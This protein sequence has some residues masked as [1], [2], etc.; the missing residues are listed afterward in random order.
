M[1][2]SNPTLTNPAQH[3]FEWKGGAGK[4]QWYDK[5]NEKNVEV[6]LPFEF[7]VLD[8]LFTITGYNKRS[9]SGFWSNEVYGIKKDLMYVKTKS[10]PF[11]A[12]LYENLTQTMKS[13]GKLARS[14]YIAHKGEGGKYMIGNIKASGSALSSWIEFRKKHA[15]DAG[16]VVMKRGEVQEAP[17]GEFYPPVFEWVKATDAEDEE[18]KALDREL[19]VYLK[20]Y[21][22]APKDGEEE[23]EVDIDEI[24]KATPEQVQDFEDRKASKQSRST[25]AADD[26]DPGP[27]KP[28]VVIE[29]IGDEPINLDD[30]PF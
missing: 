16:K 14:I 9:E 11:E 4:L 7:M 1:S 25:K 23:P 2:R 3:F 26:G 27:E 24:G 13:G 28:D 6:R 22:A 18:A 20:Q 21:I 29:D 12:A 19:Q 8:E 5:E 17:T 30:I 15:V 10:G